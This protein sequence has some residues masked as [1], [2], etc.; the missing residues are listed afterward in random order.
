LELADEPRPKP[1]ITITKKS[2]TTAANKILKNWQVSSKRLL[3]LSVQSR[4]LLEKMATRSAKLNAKNANIRIHF[5]EQLFED[6]IDSQVARLIRSTHQTVNNEVRD[7]L[8][9]EIREGNDAATVAQNLTDHYSDISATKADTI[10]RS[11]TRDATQAP[12]R[13]RTA[14]TGTYEP[15]MQGI[16]QEVCHH[17]GKPM[18]A[19]QNMAESS[20]ANT[21][22]RQLA[23]S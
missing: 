11:E 20:P 5:D 9:N 13:C 23:S 2:A 15:V 8:I 4:S 3:D 7:F 22:P 16:R 14:K 19:P 1:K 17:D 10:A 6:W 12:D 18:T 21:H